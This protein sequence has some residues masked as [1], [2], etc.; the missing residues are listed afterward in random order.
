MGAAT[1]V[2]AALAVGRVVTERLPG[3]EVAVEPRE[4]A[5]AVGEVAPLRA[6]D[7]EVTGLR[8]ARLVVPRTGAVLA[9]PGVWAVVDLGVVPRTEATTPGYVAVRAPDG[10][11]WES[12]G[13]NRVECPAPLAGVRMTCHAYVDL[14]PEALAGSQVLVGWHPTD[15]RYDDLAVVDAGVDGATVQ[16]WLAAT[17]PLELGDLEVGR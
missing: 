14:P 4:V 2:L 11:R 1:L 7:V 6:F 13:R 9:T 10:R 12:T 5:V 17:E 16:R 15:R 3:T 8:G